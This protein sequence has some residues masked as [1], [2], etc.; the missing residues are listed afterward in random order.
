MEENIE[1]VAAR[2]HYLVGSVFT[3]K[4]YRKP[5]DNWD[6]DHCQVCW[7]TIAESVGEDVNH[8]GYASTAT[9]KWRADYHWICPECFEQYREHMR[10]AVVT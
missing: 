8:A 7:R 4:P 10:W 1:M 3:R 2:L 9:E 5:S 6:H